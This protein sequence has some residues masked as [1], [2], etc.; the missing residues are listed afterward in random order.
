MNKIFKY[1]L[2]IVGLIFIL[3]IAIPIAQGFLTAFNP[4][5]SI[6]MAKQKTA[7]NKSLYLPEG[8]KLT[9]NSTSTEFEGESLYITE[10]LNGNDRIQ[11]IEMNDD[12][13]P[14]KETTNSIG[15]ISTC[16]IKGTTDGENLY[17]F[18]WIIGSKKYQLLTNDTKLT[19]KEFILLMAN[20]I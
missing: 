19:D 18:S 5:K 3:V 9:Q 2:I 12:K 13:T 4:Q 1:V 10:M 6:D 16:E 14:C 8:Y 15:Q 11:V 17:G 20:F 7:E